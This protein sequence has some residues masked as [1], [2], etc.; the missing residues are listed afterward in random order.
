MNAP[1][2]IPRGSV[3]ADVAAYYLT[4]EEKQRLLDPSI[5]GD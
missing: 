1:H 2:S 3:M 5:D 4:E